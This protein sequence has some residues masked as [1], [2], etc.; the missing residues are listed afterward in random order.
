LS[1]YIIVMH[2]VSYRNIFT[3]LL[4][5]L[6]KISGNFFYLKI[7]ETSIKIIYLDYILREISNFELKGVK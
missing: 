3:L 5:I 1:K 4:K 6:M 7:S 2:L